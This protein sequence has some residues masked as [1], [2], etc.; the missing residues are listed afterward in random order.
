MYLEDTIAAISTPAGE[1]GIGVI[2]ISGSASLSI[3]KAVFKRKYDGGFQSHRFYYGDIVSPQTTTT[4][5]EALAVYMQAPRS[6]TREDVVE[7]QCHSGTLIIQ[8]V[9]AVILLC[10]ARLAD[11]GEFTRR[12][13]LNGRI[14][15][16]QAEAII[17]MIRAKTDTAVAVARQQSDGS[18]SAALFKVR[19]LIRRALALVEAYVDFPEDDMVAKDADCLRQQINDSLSIISDLV[20]TFDEGRVIRE[21]VS[22]L[23]AGKP[24]VGKSSLLNTLLKEKRAIVTAIPGTTRDLIE[25]V[26]NIDGL[27]VKLLDTA[28][29]CTSEDTVEREG[30]ALALGRIASADLVLYVLDASRSFDADDQFVAESIKQSKIIIVLNKSDLASEIRL[31]SS[32]LSYPAIAIS[33]LS[34]T[35]IEQLKHQIALTFLHGKAVDSRELIL[36]SKSRHRDTLLRVKILLSDFIEHCAIPLPD[37]L[38]ALDLRDALDVL[39]QVTGETTPDDILNLIFEQFCVGK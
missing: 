11:P 16:L 37:E 19:D 18:L 10:G 2:R 7:I 30:I 28:G 25:E 33:T 34:L 26:V 8:Q 22:V 17:D 20:A 24:N 14:D 12:A 35:G 15:L 32:L 6:F 27:P 36:L 29:I 31:P 39:G 38:L 13:F 1:G 4:I 21:G 5:D 9:L 23:I 3:L